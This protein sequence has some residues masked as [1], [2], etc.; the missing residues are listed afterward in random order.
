M[1]ALAPSWKSNMANL[2]AH[3]IFRYG[4]ACCV[5]L[6]AATSALAGEPGGAWGKPVDGLA[7]RLVLESRYVIGQPIMPVIEIKNLCD[8]KRYI[9]MHPY[10]FRLNARTLE[11]SG[12]NG[13]IGRAGGTASQGLT[14]APILEAIGPGE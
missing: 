2:T 1:D 4:A 14:G 8:R 6:A 9:A 5:L 11:V 7:C 13:K 10:P 12:P 3:S